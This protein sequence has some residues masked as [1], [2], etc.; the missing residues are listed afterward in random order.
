MPPDRDVAFLYIGPPLGGR[1]DCPCPWPQRWPADNTG[2]VSVLITRGCGWE[3]SDND[4]LNNAFVASAERTAERKKS[5]VAPLE[6][7][8]RYK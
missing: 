6:S 2:L 4:L 7:R 1:L 3:R 8:A 5:I